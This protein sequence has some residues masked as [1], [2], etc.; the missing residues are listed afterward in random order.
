MLDSGHI[1]RGRCEQKEAGDGQCQKAPNNDEPT[2][3]DKKCTE[4]PS[5]RG[6]QSGTPGLSSVEHDGGLLELSF[7]GFPGD[8]RVHPTVT[9]HEDSQFFLLLP[10][11]ENSFEDLH[12]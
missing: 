1:L 2:A 9:L 10:F 7:A 12:G 11:F 4:S 3:T 6:G 5:L 8:D